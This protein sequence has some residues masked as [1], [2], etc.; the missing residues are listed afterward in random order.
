MV[1]LSV[2]MALESLSDQMQVVKDAE[3]T[4]LKERALRDDLIR[5]ARENDIPYRTLMRITGMSRDR[6]YTIVT[7]PRHEPSAYDPEAPVNPTLPARTG[8]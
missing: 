8:I 7:T 5:D 2:S 6:L 1:S 4:L 3:H